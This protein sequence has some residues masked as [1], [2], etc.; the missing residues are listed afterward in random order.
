MA[1]VAPTKKETRGIDGRSVIHEYGTSASNTDITIST[2]SSGVRQ[3]MGVTVKYGGAASTTITITHNFLGGPG[4]TTYDV[5][6]KSQALSAAADFFWQPD[7]PWYLQDGDTVTVVA[8]ALSG[9][10]TRVLIETVG[11]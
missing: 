3:L 9:Q 10:T 1:T 2:G 4:G 11:I 6:L 5:L 8:P 7:A